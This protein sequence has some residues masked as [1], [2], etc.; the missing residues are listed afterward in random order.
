MAVKE[1]V[2]VKLIRTSCATADENKQRS[3]YSMRLCQFASFGCRSTTTFGVLRRLLVWD[4]KFC[5]EKP[6]HAVQMILCNVNSEILL[7]AKTAAA[8][9]IATYA[10]AI[11][12]GLTAQMVSEFIARTNLMAK[13]F[14]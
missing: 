10:S 7:W 4:L 11:F 2:F 5:G 12:V 8:Y 1:S 14:L 6:K 9:V 3:K 13:F